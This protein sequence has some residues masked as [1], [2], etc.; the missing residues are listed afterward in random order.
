M[1]ERQKFGSITV[2]CAIGRAQNVD[3]VLVT[4]Y[5]F[6]PKAT[7]KGLPGTSLHMPFHVLIIPPKTEPP[8]APE[9]GFCQATTGED[10][11]ETITCCNSYG[12]SRSLCRTNLLGCTR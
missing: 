9:E 1:A 8:A 2:L 6:L 11:P 4:Y 10:V 5:P 3:W 12:S 7:T